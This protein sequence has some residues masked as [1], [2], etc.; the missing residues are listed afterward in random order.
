MPKVPK[1]ETNLGCRIVD[2]DTAHAIALATY[3][4]I[5]RL[6]RECDIKYLT[7]LTA[8]S[9][10]PGCLFFQRSRVNLWGDDHPTCIVNWV[11]AITP[12]PM[13]ADDML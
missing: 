7:P 9:P 10:S 1:L 8:I 13:H 11:K 2:F 12:N 6:P 5:H 3:A 4:S